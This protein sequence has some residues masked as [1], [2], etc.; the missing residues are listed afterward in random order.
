MNV[1]IAI[2][3]L[4]F[5][6]VYFFMKFGKPER[7]VVFL[8]RQGDVPSADYR[9]L[10]GALES[11]GVKTEMYL[12][13]QEKD[14]AR[15][16]GSAGGNLRMILRQMKALA[17]ARVAVTDGYAIPVSIL[18]HHKALTVIQLWH[19]AGAV[20]KFGLQALPH[21]SGPERRR[22]AA[23]KMHQGYDVFVAPSE[24]TA[25]FFA[26][27]F[28]MTPEKALITGT[29]YL[30]ALYAGDFE[31]REKILRAYPCLDGGAAGRSDRKAN[32]LYLPTYRTEQAYAGER[33]GGQGSAQGTRGAAR[34]LAEALDPDRYNLIVRLHPV[35]GAG[36]SAGSDDGG[37]ACPGAAGLAGPGNDVSVCSGARVF[38]LPEFSAEELFSVADCV[39]TDYS[40]LA[41]VAGLAE[42]PVYFFLYDAEAYRDSPGLNIDPEDVYEK[43]TA[44]DAAAL[45]DRIDAPYD[46]EYE[47][48]FTDAYI[49]VFDGGCTARLTAKII[50]YLQ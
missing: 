38:E 1:L 10:A 50:E 12:Q 7:K 16:M 37:S 43:Y 18:K 21:M 25:Q 39:V 32:V 6:C 26:E 30:D 28:G 33:A 3:K 14:E 23:L 2:G 17:T 48:S 24:K 47:R 11:E 9:M 8:S 44:R 36:G 40:S 46:M 20:K 41:L 29:P 13:R 22:A 4:F 42:I 49:E 35:E 31:C 19:A 27:A 34:A 45:A 15:F 5:R